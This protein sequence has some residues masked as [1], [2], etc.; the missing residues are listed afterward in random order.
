[1]SVF[2]SPISVEPA[3]KNE[4]DELRDREKRS[5]RMASLTEGAKRIAV[6]SLA[7]PHLENMRSGKKK[8]EVRLKK[9]KWAELHEGDYM[10]FN[11]SLL[12]KVVS[13]TEYPHIE[14]LLTTEDLSSILPDIK[15]TEVETAKTVYRA[16]FKDE[17]DLYP[18]LK[19]GVEVVLS[20]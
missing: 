6:G 4:T 18:A 12:V 8:F 16:C 7:S 3:R 13:R 10:L 14:K 17:Y 20:K 1:M 5:V 15:G 11:G 2:W 19:F 9:G